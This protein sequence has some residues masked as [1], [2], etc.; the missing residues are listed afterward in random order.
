MTAHTAI[1]LFGGTFD[2][3]H[4]GHLR[5]ASEAKEKLGLGDFRLLPVGR[6]AHRN[7]THASAEHRLAMLRLAV[8]EHPDITVDNRE[9]RRSGVSYM[10]DTLAEIRGEAGTDRAILLILGQDAAHGLCSWYR[11]QE[12]FDYAHLVVMTR[13]DSP[14]SFS[15]QLES[16]VT[17]RR[18]NTMAD[19]WRS[20]AGLLLNL[21]VTQLAISSTAIR[22]QVAQNRSPRFLLPDRILGYIG[23]HQLYPKADK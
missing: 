13:P 4:F 2:P 19:L 8:A 15:T 3:V 22:Q 21:E 14:A 5:A 23:F 9:V 12:L 20:P 6:P 7:Q 10:V 1:G 11:W 18:C 17:T 16:F